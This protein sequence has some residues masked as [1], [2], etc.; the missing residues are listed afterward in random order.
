M[1]S[2][3]F[4]ARRPSV[5]KR[6]SVRLVLESLEPRTAPAVT[7]AGPEFLINQAT[8]GDQRTYAESPRAVAV[9]S[10]GNFVVTW[11]GQ[12]G[13]GEGVYFRRF[14]A[15]GQPLGPDIR[16][17][18][19]TGGDQS[20]STVAMDAVGNF[21][22]AWTDA[23]QDGSGSGVY[24]K[25]FSAAGVA[26]QVPGETPGVT[27]FRI[28]ST[29]LHSQQYPSVAMDASGDFIVAWQSTAGQDSDSWGVYAQRYRAN[30]Q[31]QGSEFLVNSF[32]AGQQRNPKVAVGASGD[33]VITWMSEGQ[34]G[35]GW[36]V[37]AKRYDAAGV[38]QE[39]PGAPGQ[40]E[41][42]V[43]SS[44]AGE[45]LYSSVAAD[46]AGNFVII[47]FGD[48]PGGSG[49]D[50][51]GKRYNAAGVAQEVPGAPGQSEFRV[52]SSTGGDQVNPAVGLDGDG[53]F[54]VSWNNPGQDGDGNGVYARRYSAAGVAQSDEFQ[55]NTF[56]VGQQRD[57]SVGVSTEGDFIIAWTSEGQDGSGNG[58]Y[59]Q[60]YTGST[61]IE[62]VRAAG[63]STAIEPGERLVQTIT[64]G[65]N[66]KVRFSRGMTRSSAENAVSHLP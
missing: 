14:D 11:S 26:Q 9:D 34:S 44:I 40:T 63:D 28:N 33:F 37:Y 48:G 15:T 8:A 52:N 13:D 20:F 27:E 50:I 21:V 12:D 24:A 36:E 56:T 17:N 49:F 3:Y 39:V 10:A 66:L 64:A 38:A 1:K 42:R 6:S 41:F 25:R 35:S 16:V 54:V 65:P 59:A 46:A 7:V 62:E 58:V 60:R 43:N 18:S 61:R 5:V 4:G 31:Q 2:P 19:F 57:A 45:Q 53:D 22:V 55:V 51:Y 30:G 23:V 32:T 47:W 29:T